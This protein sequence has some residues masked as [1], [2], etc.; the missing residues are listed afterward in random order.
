MPEGESIGMSRS[1][2]LRRVL[3][4]LTALLVLGGC[5]G[6]RSGDLS[7]AGREMSL[8]I[9][10]VRDTGDTEGNVARL[11]VAVKGV[12]ITKANGDTSGETGHLHVFVDRPAVAEGAL[13]PKEAGIIHSASS[14]I[15]IPGLTRGTHHFV[16]VIGDGA[17]RRMGSTHAD[18]RAVIAGKS[19]HAT[20]P[21]QIKAG[22]ALTVTIDVIGFK[23]V[24]ADGNTTGE[25]GHLHVIVDPA[26]DPTLVGVDPFGVLPFP[27]VPGVIHTADT[28]VSVA[29]L[30]KGDHTIYV[31]ASNGA[32]S[33]LPGPVMDVLQV[34]VA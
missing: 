30:A 16:V 23:L 19:V 20:A 10:K 18:G 9:T 7:T 33:P 15:L 21:P 6:D 13:I 26:T 29:G 25:T 1:G 8:R 12:T 17:H 31:V 27:K 2:L 4:L 24:K 3:L 11:W 5:A 22:D 32:H 14:P 34:K 28:T